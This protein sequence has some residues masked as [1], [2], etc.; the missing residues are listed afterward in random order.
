MGAMAFIIF[1]I[2]IVQLEKAIREESEKEVD[3]WRY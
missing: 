2:L 3:E 1:P